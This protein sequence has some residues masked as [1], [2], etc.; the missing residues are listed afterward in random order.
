MKT[1]IRWVL[2]CG[3]GSVGWIVGLFFGLWG[4]LLG[5]VLG[6]LGAVLALLSEVLGLL[7]ALLSLLGRWVRCWVAHIFNLA[8]FA[9]I[10]MAQR[11]NKLTSYVKVL[12]DTPPLGFIL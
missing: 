11:G 9:P 3:V 7:G 12:S 6:P 8:K 1:V 10:Q 4:A 5:E 2:G